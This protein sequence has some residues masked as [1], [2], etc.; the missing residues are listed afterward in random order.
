MAVSDQ[1]SSNSFFNLIAA[2][3]NTNLTNILN[4]VTDGAHPQPNV[5][6]LVYSS[7]YS[8]NLPTISINCL[9][10]GILRTWIYTI[11]YLG[12]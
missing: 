7:I 1:L 12:Y 10:K 11:H 6:G 5:H 8:L 4:E 2:V 3:R 9:Y